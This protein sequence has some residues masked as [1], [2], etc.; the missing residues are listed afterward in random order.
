MVPQSVCMMKKPQWNTKGN[1]SAKKRSFTAPE[2]IF[3]A[4]D[5]PMIKTFLDNR[6]FDNAERFCAMPFSRNEKCSVEAAA[7]E[8]AV[9]V[10]ERC[11]VSL[12]CFMK[13]QCA[14]SRECVLVK[15][16]TVKRKEN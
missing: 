10:C 11:R 6:C 8:Q 7:A 4:S 16:R 1:K 15:L 2:C 13:W 3:R 9:S 14:V 12:R 5:F